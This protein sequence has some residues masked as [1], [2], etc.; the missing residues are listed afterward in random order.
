MNEA[1]ADE[2]RENG[3]VLLASRERPLQDLY[4]PF[5]NAA[6]VSCNSATIICKELVLR[7]RTRYGTY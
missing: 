2:V 6:E 5:F 4:F 3:A 7:R 1:G